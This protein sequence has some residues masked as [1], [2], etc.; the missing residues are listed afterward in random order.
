M[1]HIRFNV[2]NFFFDI[3]KYKYKRG[4]LKRE[5]SCIKQWKK[6]KYFN[7]IINFKMSI[8][9]F[10]RD[11]VF[12]FDNLFK[13]NCKN[14]FTLTEEGDSSVLFRTTM[15]L[16]YMFGILSRPLTALYIFGLV[17]NGSSNSLWP[18]LRKQMKSMITSF[19]NFFR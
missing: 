19:W 3:N 14:N 17:K 16:A 4:I 6:L 12:E 9:K 11:D 18:C 7:L 15:L 2:L 5:F 1:Y 8:G 10:P 13:Q